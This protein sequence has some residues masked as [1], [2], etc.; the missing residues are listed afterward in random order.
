MKSLVAAVCALTIMAIGSVVTAQDT[1]HTGWKTS[2]IF[3]VTG[4]QTAYSESWS[5]GE[6]GTLSWVSNLNGSVEKQLS[7]SFNIISKLKL[8][9]GQTHFQKISE[10]AEGNEIKIWEKP[11]KTTDL[12]DWENVGRLTKA[13]AVDP[14]IAFRL[15]SQFLDASI[16]DYKRHLTPLKLTESGG[17]AKKLYEKDKDQIIS[18][19]GLAVRQIFIKGVIVE[20]TNIAIDTDP[21]L[22]TPDDTT[23]TDGGIESV[24]DIKLS[25]RENIQYTGKLTLYKALF[26]SG[27]DEV[28][29]TAQEDYWKAI[30]VN[31]ENIITASITKIISVN[32]YMQL[33][34]DKEI[35]KRG[36]LKETMGIGIVIKMI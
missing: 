19:L 30:D 9:F 24:T 11:Q 32:F 6:A 1:T 36:R 7:S 25:L 8:S 26:F 23:L 34:Y 35:D 27:K 14:Y 17:I 15:E 3:D 31:W 10:D 13:W 18:R 4:T 20:D 22:Y 21:L 2:L 29:G 12:I 16:R 28:K 5:G 33:L